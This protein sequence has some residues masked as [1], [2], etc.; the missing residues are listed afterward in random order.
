MM[1]YGVNYALPRAGEVVRTG[2]VARRTGTSFA[3]VLGTV[4]LDRL[5]DMAMLAVG[6]A[7]V[8][9]LLRDRLEPLG[10]LF[11]TPV[12]NRLDGLPLLLIAGVL[13]GGVGLGIVFGL[14]RR[15]RVAARR[16]A[17]TPPTPGR[18][19][20]LVQSFFEGLAALARAPRR[21]TLVGTTVAMWGLYVL[22]AY[23]PFLLLRTAAPYGLTLVDAWCI[24]LLGAIGMVVPSPGG[25]GSFHYVTILTLTGLWGVARDDAA[26]Y[27]V[28]AHAAQLVVYVAAGVLSFL[29]LAMIGEP[30]SN[31]STPVP[32][33][34]PAP[35]DGSDTAV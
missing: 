19:H 6:L 12:R 28:L 14:R 24:M 27:A 3:A 33:A 32:D 1:G 23:F 5:L 16:E 11:L 8:P 34:S 9:F 15:A 13:A 4:V 30:A 29:F 31:R 26:A 2:V 21:G 22:M 35:I 17:A 18:L 7:T 25:A 20:R 10:A